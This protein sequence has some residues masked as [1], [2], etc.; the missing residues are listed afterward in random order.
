MMDFRRPGEIAT[1]PQVKAP[2]VMCEPPILVSPSWTV[3]RKM[4]AEHQ[5]RQAAAAQVKERLRTSRTAPIPEAQAQL[6]KEAGDK[7]LETDA[8]YPESQGLGPASATVLL[9]LPGSAR[10]YGLVGYSHSRGDG[11]CSPAQP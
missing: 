1:C 11:S 10:I 4:E 3:P 2:S 9:P 5:V 8:A 6:V 7:A